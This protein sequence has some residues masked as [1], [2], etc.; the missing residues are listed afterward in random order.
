MLECFLPNS[1]YHACP[2]FPSGNSCCGGLYMN[3]CQFGPTVC[4][5]QHLHHLSPI[6]FQVILKTRPW[7]R[8]C[9][10]E[11]QFQ[12]PF[13]ICCLFGGRGSFQLWRRNLMKYFIHQ[14]SP[15]CYSSVFCH[16]Q[17][18]M[19]VHWDCWSLRTALIN[20]KSILPIFP[21]SSDFKMLWSNN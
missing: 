11:W 4:L 2:D 12:W 14:P 15:E 1:S 13:S 6:T 18:R 5:L 10:F 3:F 9:E 16:F 21:I 20:V 19:F 8:I 7:W 17:N